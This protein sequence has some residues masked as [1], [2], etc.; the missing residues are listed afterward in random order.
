MRPAMFVAALVVSPLVPQ[1]GAQ[2][3]TVSDSAIQ[4]IVRS[5]VDSKIS[6]GIVVGVIDPNGHRR[7][8]AYGTSATARPLDARSV[9]EIG[10]ITKTFTATLLA[11]MVNRGEVSLSDPVAKFLP[12]GVT[13]PERNGKQITLLDLATQSSGLPGN[14][15]NMHPADAGNPYADYTVAQLYAF[16]GSYTLPRDIGSQYEYSNV[17]VGLLGHALARRLGMPYDEALRRRVLDPLGL[18]DTRITLTSGMRVRLA[19]GHDEAGDVVP[20][21]DLPALAGAGALRSTLNDMLDY[22]AAN[23][24]A[25]VDSTRMPLGAAMHNAH[26]RRRSA[27]GPMSIGLLWHLLP[28]SN[29]VSVV[30]H[31]GGTG[32]YRTFAGFNPE[33]HTG[34]VVLSNSKVSVD[35][36]G[37]HL[38]APAVP[39]APPTR[40]SWVGKP[41]IDVPAAVLQRYVGDYV[42]SP[43]F[44]IAITRAPRGQALQATGQPRVDLFA[45]SPTDFYLKE[46]DASITFQVDASGA[47]TGL[48]LHQSGRDQRA[49]R[50]P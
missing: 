7:V 22:V 40:P 43:E 32:G 33:S 30:W 26:E 46:V 2:A 20:N 16:L 38:L 1:V 45:E 9:F 27:A 42:L 8:F 37:V 29:T 13:V 44:H 14:I 23:M 49:T 4:A 24:A 5:R 41:S 21:W 50:A 31:N 15:P 25:D 36:I 11:D 48:V 10:S 17:G 6:T 3:A 18:N 47:V 39:P 19:L 34:V 28:V 35:D 12:A